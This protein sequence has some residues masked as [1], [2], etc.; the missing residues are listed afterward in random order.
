M[1]AGLGYKEF[2]V[3]DILTAA[4]AN[5]YLASQTV[6]V[7]ADSAARTAAITSPQEGMIS[8]L[9][10][11]NATQYYSGSAWVSI[12]GGASPLTTKGDLYTFSTVDARLAVGT[13]GQ[14]LTADSTAGTGLK[15]AS[16]SSGMTLVKKA[17]FSAVASTTTTF[18]GV[19]TSTYDTY[20]IVGE[21]IISSAGSPNLLFQFRVGASTQST[22]DYYGAYF[23]Y[24]YLNSLTSAGTN[25]GSSFI[26]CQAGG[27]GESSGFNVTTNKVV[28][29]NTTQ[30][31]GTAMEASRAAPLALGCKYNTAISADG[32]ILSLSSGNITGTVAVYGLAKA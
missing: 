21:K 25:G 26:M 31:F 1:A 20:V 23:G 17:S 19:F 6:M 24:N 7:F 11:T 9:K 8:Y 30:I 3:G 13:N 12:G 29:S 32:F 14:V 16:S 15:W 4:D 10:D 18:D 5:G 28:S 27:G 2:L 22:S